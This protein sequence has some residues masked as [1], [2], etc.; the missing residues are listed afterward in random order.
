MHD[1]LTFSAILPFLIS[2][3]AQAG[4]HSRATYLGGGGLVILEEHLHLHPS[5]AENRLRESTTNI[6]VCMDSTYQQENH[7]RKDDFENPRVPCTDTLEFLIST[8]GQI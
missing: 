3:A 7:Y 1:S 2:R 5:S 6:F 4:R 8:H